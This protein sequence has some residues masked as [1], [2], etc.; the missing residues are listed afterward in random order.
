[1]VIRVKGARENNLKSVDVE[2]QSGLTV[3]TGVSG[4][5]KSSLVFE[6]LY[7][8]ARR[9]FEDVFQFGSMSQRLVPAQVDSITGLGPA[10][11]VGQNLLNR[12]PNSVLATASGLHPFLRLLYARFGTR[13]CSE[14]GEPINMLSED[15]IVSEILHLN[16][17]SFVSVQIPLVTGIVGSHRSLLRMLGE[18]FGDV[19][20]MVDGCGYSGEKLDQMKPHSIKLILDDIKKGALHQTIREKVQQARG[21]GA[22]SIIIKTDNKTEL[23]STARI[24]SYCGEW[25]KELQ[26]KDFHS[27]ISENVA[28]VTWN[29]LNLDKLLELDVNSAYELFK[30]SPLMHQSQRLHHEIMKRLESLRKVGLGYINLKRPSPTLSRGESQRVRLA[31]SLTSSLEDILHILDEPTIGQHPHDVSR[32][33]PTFRELKGPVIYVEHDRVA[34]ALADYAVDIGPGAGVAGGEIV[35]KG[36]PS[37]LWKAE[38]STGRY[39]SLRERVQTGKKRVYPREFII[40]KGAHRHNL[41]DIDVKIPYGCLTTITGVSGSG[42]STLVEDVLVESMREGKPVGCREIECSLRP[43]LVD[44]SPIGR[45]PRSTPATYTKLS[46]IIR[47][48]YAER[49]GSRCR[50]LPAAAAAP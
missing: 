35:Y 10:V 30:E 12:N 36:T 14:C 7:H 24:C 27:P 18:E 39:F 26:P 5:G 16:K 45:N 49:T 37:Q 31:V 6:T 50:P 4:S 42:K 33:V 21:L 47:D 20:L 40:I 1:M 32:I 13:V 19:S 17:D 25:F 34:A 8:E 2:F 3:V 46:E 15:E 28:G 38:T 41:K 9:R 11:A 23:Y 29:G 22:T 43:V 44:Q 48:Y